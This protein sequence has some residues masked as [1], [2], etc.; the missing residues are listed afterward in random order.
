MDK[1]ER[2]ALWKRIAVDAV[3]AS[4]REGADELE[5][6]QFK[7]E[8]DLFAFFD[9][10]RPDGAGLEKVF[11]GVVGGEEI[12][13]RLRRIY[14][15]KETATAFGYF[16]VRRSIPASSEALVNL[17]IEHLE[18]VRQIAIH[19]DEEWLADQLKVLPDIKIKREAIS[20]K[21]RADFDA[22]ESMVYEVTGDWFRSLEPIQSDALLME[23]AFY[24]IA[25]DYKI[26]HFLMWPLYR[27][28]SEIE[29][30]F[31]PYFEL[32]THAALPFFEEPGLVTI[33]VSGEH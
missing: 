26:A 27:S 23:E 17:T 4:G 3:R 9:C 30:P 21:T 31:K 1:L 13:Q 11:A 33:Y 32:W 5:A 14:E 28:H 18:K 8:D 19:F 25:C 12:L 22:P 20:D 6:A 15:L 7:N 29:D 10:F 24:S 2:L 16:V